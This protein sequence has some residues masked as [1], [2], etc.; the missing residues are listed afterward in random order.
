MPVMRTS[1]ALVSPNPSFR[2]TSVTLVA[3]NNA[4]SK[5]RIDLI[6]SPYISGVE[7]GVVKVHKSCGENL[8]ILSDRHGGADVV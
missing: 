1:V 6:A 2:I 7:P 8:F 3:P 5:Y 4:V